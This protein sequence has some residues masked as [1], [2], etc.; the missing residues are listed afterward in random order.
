[1]AEADNNF[2]SHEEILNGPL[3]DMR[4][5]VN[6]RKQYCG[7]LADTFYYEE[8][9][10]TER[11]EALRTMNESM[12]EKELKI[13]LAALSIA[14]ASRK[15]VVVSED[16]APIILFAKGLMDWNKE[17][18]AKFA[19]LRAILTEAGDAD[20]DADNGSAASVASAGAGGANE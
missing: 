19:K 10:A 13:Q 14:K 5:L 12:T 6:G 18:E 17:L 20:E 4:P 3:V 2:F 16:S 7:M 9:Y 15:K 8:E 1:M 11:R